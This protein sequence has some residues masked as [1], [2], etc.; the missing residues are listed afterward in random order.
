[1]GVFINSL[2]PSFNSGKEIDGLS[3]LDEVFLTNVESQNSVLLSPNLSKNPY[4]C[5]FPGDNV[6]SKSYINAT[7]GLPDLLVIT[8][9]GNKREKVN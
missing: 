3:E 1:M 2:K 6:P 8:N 9:S 7:T 5:I 4:S